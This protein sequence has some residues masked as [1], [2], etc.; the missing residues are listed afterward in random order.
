LING[1]L[2]LLIFIL[3]IF[4]IFRV[5]HLFFFVSIVFLWLFQG[6]WGSVW[7]CLLFRFFPRIGLSDLSKVPSLFVLDFFD[8][9]K[10]LVK[11]S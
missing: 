1:F 6:S 10:E 2:F 11:P 8:F 7:G 5:F 4:E 9:D 3:I